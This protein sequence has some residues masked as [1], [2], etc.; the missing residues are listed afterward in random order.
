ML[1]EKKKCVLEVINAEIRHLDYFGDQE[2]RNQSFLLKVYSIRDTC[3]NVELSI[4]FRYMLNYDLF[5]QHRDEF[6]IRNIIDDTNSCFNEFI[7]YMTHE[8]SRHIQAC[9]VLIRGC[10]FSAKHEDLEVHFFGLPNGPKIGICISNVFIDNL[11]NLDSQTL[12]REEFG[13]VM[14]VERYN[15]EDDE[16]YQD[17]GFVAYEGV[18]RKNIDM[19]FRLNR[20]L[21]Y[22]D[23]LN[24]ILDLLVYETQ[25]SDDIFW[26]TQ[27]II[28]SSIAKNNGIFTFK[29][30]NDIN[31][32]HEFI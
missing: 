31:A 12:Y 6:V 10:I 2:L 25:F 3:S 8:V 26:E 32:S 28:A 13:E 14:S 23:K 24:K 4:N 7:S 15:E 11:I 22:G 30:V 19:A 18:T 5:C 9:P 1:K 16:L 17:V 27:K 20:K 21:L 29:L